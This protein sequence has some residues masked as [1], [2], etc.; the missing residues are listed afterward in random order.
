M[1][2]IGANLA[3]KEFALDVGPIIDNAFMNGVQRIIITGS[4]HRSSQEAKR[5]ADIYTSTNTTGDIKQQSCLLYSTAGFHP[6]NAKS[7]SYR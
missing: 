4:D 6:H 5:I 7:F 3:D 1:I 2:D